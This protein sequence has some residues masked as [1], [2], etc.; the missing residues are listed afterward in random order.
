MGGGVRRGAAVLAPLVLLAGAVAGAAGGRPAAG[1]GRGG[2]GAAV[3]RLDGAFLS[4][5]G[6]ADAFG[7]D[8][9]RAELQ[10]MAGVGMTIVAL[11]PGAAEITSS[12]SAACPFG[13]WGTFFPPPASL[14]PTCFKQVGV[15][16]GG[17]K[18]TSTLGLILQAAWEAGIE[19]HTGLAFTANK[20]K[21]PRA[22]NASSG[23]EQFATHEEKWSGYAALEVS[24]A[25]AVWELFGAEYQG[26][27]A[28][29]YTDVEVNNLS[30]FLDQTRSLATRFYRAFAQNVKLLDPDLQVWASPYFVGNVTRRPDDQI[31]DPDLWASWWR[32]I[33]KE[34][35]QFDF[36]APQDAMGFQGNSFQNVTDYLAAL[37]PA[38][39]S[40]DRPLWSNVELF[41]GWPPSCQWPGPCGRHPAPIERVKAQLANE[42]PFTEKMISW[43]WLSCLSPYTSDDT[44]QLYADYKEYLSGGRSALKP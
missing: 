8:E 3:P 29:F 10:A 40:M 9:W 18:G 15:G 6:S 33:F 28:G 16:V 14:S 21:D 25:K 36:L 13:R 37:L 26:T 35:P 23:A 30:V 19:V 34:A 38:S 39:A 2:G 22:W 27:L 32:Q 12:P 44:A 41:E 24:L 7:L 4:I 11:R 17:D 43:E 31:M 1:L 20:S 42:S 5:H